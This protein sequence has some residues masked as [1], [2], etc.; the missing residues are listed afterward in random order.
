MK[1]KVQGAPALN[2]DST[3]LYVSVMNEKHLSLGG[4]SGGIYAL[5]ASVRWGS[6]GQEDGGKVLGYASVVSLFIP[7]SA[8]IVRPPVSGICAVLSFFFSLIFGICILSGVKLLICRGSLL[9]LGL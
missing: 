8:Q 7:I 1:G 2:E 4:M 5:D 9:F 6:E 3:V